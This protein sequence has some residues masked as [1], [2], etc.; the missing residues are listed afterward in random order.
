MQKKRG[1]KNLV[2]NFFSENQRGQVTIFIIIALII[3]TGVVIF[4]VFRQNIQMQTIPASIQPVY[5]S[6]LSCLEDKTKTGVDVLESQGG[7]IE[8]PNPEAGSPYMPFS[9]Q[10]NFFGNS[11]PYW[12]YVSANNL[13][14]EQIPSQTDMENSLEK[15]LNDRIRDCSFASFYDQGFEIIQEE[16]TTTV[17]IRN[18]NVDVKVNMDM[19]INFGNDT[20]LIT[21]HEVVVNSKLGTLYNSAKTVYDKEQKEL[22]LEN[23]GVDTMRLY[24]PV[25]GVNLTCS[26]AIWNADDVFSNLQDAIET[27]TLAIKTQS[28]S[29]NNEKYFYVSGTNGNVRFINS[30]SWP[31]SF[32]VLPSQENILIANPVGNQLGLGILGFCYVPYHFVYN[33]KYPVLVQVYDGDETFQFPL[34]V[35]ILGNKPRTALNS[36]SKAETSDLC[37]YKNV[38]T[39]VS[40]YDSNM[41]SIDASVSYECFGESCT[42]GKTSSGK[43]NSNFPQ[44]INGYIVA[45]ADGY[46]ETKLLY[47]TN[48]EGSASVILDK[49]YDLNVNLKLGGNN[50]NGNAMIYFT[51]D[52]SQIISYPQQKNVK[53]SEGTYNVSV[54]IYKDSS[55]QL[56]GGTTQQ[57]VD[58]LSSGIGGIFGM[59]EK[60]CVDVKIPSQIVSNVLAGGGV[61]TYSLSE[62]S[63]KSSDTIEISA[64]ELKT[65]TSMEELQNNYLIFDTKQL[66]I[67]LT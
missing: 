27:N 25:D 11:I 30:K 7:Y 61:Q 29:N 47:S 46:K 51:G 33:I 63:L 1:K 5:S 62:S 12:Y 20:A 39:T 58:V 37:S 9:S 50:Y 36:S 26:P 41:N 60:K 59:T 38:P 18:D 64:E 48:N 55:I 54:Y 57:C 43:I 2:N 23:Y 16:P 6:F 34:A 3:V 14:K 45:R 17:S 40:T 4:L 22:F 66:E 15:F 28:P 24:A 53:L 56:N 19:S 52:N 10:L 35:V 8:L 21:N 31:S 49:L 42:I 32:E 67:N 44:C 13:Q 65:P